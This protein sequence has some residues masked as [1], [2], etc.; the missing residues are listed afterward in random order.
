M[1]KLLLLIIL[2]FLVSCASTKQ[3]VEFTHGKPI[4]GKDGQIDHLISE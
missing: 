2:I 1:K 4:D 3:Y